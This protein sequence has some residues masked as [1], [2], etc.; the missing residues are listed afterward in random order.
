MRFSLFRSSRRL[1]VA[2]LLLVL[3]A[4]RG[5]GTANGATGRE[6]AITR[7]MAD[8]TAVADDRGEWIGDDP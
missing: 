5:R 8:P 6:L 2:T 7:V 4:C 1:G 3:V